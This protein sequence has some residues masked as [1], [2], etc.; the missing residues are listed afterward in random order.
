MMVVVVENEP[1]IR[2]DTVRK[3][4]I[5]FFVRNNHIVILLYTMVVWIY[6]ANGNLV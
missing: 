4:D 3:R 6:I 5:D 1:S 2:T